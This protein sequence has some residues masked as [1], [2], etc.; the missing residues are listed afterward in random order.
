MVS[1]SFAEQ[2]DYS[3]AYKW[4]NIAVAVGIKTASKKERND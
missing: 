3:N 4:Y 1:F 2:V